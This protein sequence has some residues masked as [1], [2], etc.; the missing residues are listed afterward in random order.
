M[1]TC[2]GADIVA[3]AER[4]ARGDSTGFGSSFAGQV[5]RLLI[6]HGIEGILVCS[7]SK[8]GELRQGHVLSINIPRWADESGGLGFHLSRTLYGIRLARYAHRNRVDLAIID[9]GTAHYFSLAAFRIFRIP[10]A[11]NFHNVRWPIGFEPT[12]LVR[13]AIRYLDSAFFRKIPVAALGCSPECQ[14]QACADGA[15]VLPFFSWTGQY[16]RE[17]F[18]PSVNK[19]NPDQPFRLMF[20]GR[21]EKNK[22][23]FDLLKIIATL[24]QRRGRAVVVEVCGDGTALP[25][26]RS[27]VSLL[28]L[29][30]VIT[31]RGRLSGLD[32]TA[33]YL[34]SDA[35]IVPT[36]GDFCEGMPLVCAEA[37]LS[38]KPIITS[39]LSN[40]LPVLGAAI[41]EAEPE[42]IESYVN[43]I[44]AL[45]EDCV[46]YNQLQ[47]ECFT[48]SAQFFDRSKCYA[49]AVDRLIAATFPRH[50]PLTDYESISV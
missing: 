49:A 30:S 33:A 38:G 14:K 43:A 27:K 41:M 32:L 23:V 6:A 40:A 2:G 1:L 8:G 36:R 13:R 39:R 45:A 28:G 11:V 3:D 4:E 24:S 19:Q 16:K 34:R 47:A 20:A 26:L 18:S 46:K 15:N 5:R 31:I 9:S 48:V 17:A 21:V 35:V 50:V 44:A 42:N 37:V 7:N 29:G 10:V 22:G 25:E 12:G